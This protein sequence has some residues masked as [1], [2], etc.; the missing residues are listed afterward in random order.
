M[1]TNPDI[2]AINQDQLGNQCQEVE[3]FAQGDVRG[4]SSRVVTDGKAWIAILLVNWGETV[5]ES[6]TI[7][8]VKA[9]IAEHPYDQCEVYDLY[10]HTADKKTAD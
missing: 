7:D 5:S 9:G 4:Y 1:L 6:I 10:S 8:L 2:I 3:A